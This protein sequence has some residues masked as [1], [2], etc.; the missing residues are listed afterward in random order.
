MTDAR[1]TQEALE[2]WAMPNA[3]AQATTVL[4]EMWGPGGTTTPRAVVTQVALEQWGVVAAAT[5]Q[6]RV[7]IMA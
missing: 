4:V 5:Q 7:W 2:F 6:S 3:N 1:V